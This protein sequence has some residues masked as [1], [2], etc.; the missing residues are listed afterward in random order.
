MLSMLTVLLF[1]LTLLEPDV[2]RVFYVF[3]L[4][5]ICFTKIHYRTWVICLQHVRK[6]GF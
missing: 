3:V 4:L 6:V 1:S 5:S 2:L